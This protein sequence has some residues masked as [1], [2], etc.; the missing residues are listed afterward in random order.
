MQGTFDSSEVT[1]LENRNVELQFL[2]SA[3]ALIMMDEKGKVRINKQI[4][5]RVNAGKIQNLDWHTNAAGA[6]I[7]EV[8]MVASKK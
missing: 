8:T 4:L 2:M 5:N 1:A 7:M 6:V 3:M